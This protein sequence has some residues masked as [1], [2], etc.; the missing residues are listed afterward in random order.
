MNPPCTH[1][2]IMPA[3]TAQQIVLIVKLMNTLITMFHQHVHNFH[4]YLDL[5]KVNV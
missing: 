3:D 1:A 2:T 5:Y 4:N